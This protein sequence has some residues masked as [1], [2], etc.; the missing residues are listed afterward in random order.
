MLHLVKLCV[1]IDTV[2]ALA[3][4]QARRLAQAEREGRPAELRH[5]TRHRPRR[6]DEI[7][8]GGSLYWVIQGAIR[9]RQRIVRIDELTTPVDGKRTALI[10]APERVRTDPWGRRPHQGWRYLEAA[11]APPDLPPGDADGNEVPPEMLA[12][13]RRLGLL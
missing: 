10:L 8:A 11:D 6:A 5:V 2:E 9:V 7:L 13:L 1:G 12:E 4:A 3:A